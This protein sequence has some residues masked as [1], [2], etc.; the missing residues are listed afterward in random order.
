MSGIGD[1]R[2]ATG[3]NAN[4]FH[5]NINICLCHMEATEKPKQAACQT[6]TLMNFAS[7]S[8]MLRGCEV[9]RGWSWHNRTPL[10]ALAAFA[11]AVGSRT[12]NMFTRR[13]LYPNFK[14]FLEIWI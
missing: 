7:E 10:P 3:N 11:R 2:L 12:I 14:A 6:D 5:T 4:T 1:W 8:H 9:A 13:M